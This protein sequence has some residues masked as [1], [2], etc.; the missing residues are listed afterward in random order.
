MYP[1]PHHLDQDPVHL[2]SVIETFSLA[3]LISSSDNEV[4]VTHLP[5]ILDS[6]GGDL[7]VL[8][9]HLDRQNPQGELLDG[10]TVTAIFQGPDCYISPTVYATRQLPTWNYVAVHVR[11]RS[12]LMS[13]DEAV[14][15]SIVRMIDY[16]E[17]A[18]G[19]F[20]LA[21]DDP[22]VAPL[23]PHIIGFEIEITEMTG[24]FK[25]SQDKGVKDREQAKER[26]IHE[27][28]SSL[29]NFIDSVI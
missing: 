12:T 25:L 6:S 11:G 5:L 14:R 15:E 9:G 27:A 21:E 13:S 28:E 3:T 7:G 4:L 23:L 29:R 10:R 18:E 26:L 17:P 22:R 19:G 24:R 8:R 1:P 2:R 20:S 16:L